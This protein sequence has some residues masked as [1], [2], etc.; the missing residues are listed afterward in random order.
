PLAGPV[1]AAAVIVPSGCRLPGVHDSKR[2]SVAEREQAALLV[3]GRCA[4]GIGVATVEEIDRL[5]ILRATF[6]AMERAIR[7]LPEPA[8]GVLVDGKF[9]TCNLAIPAETVVRGDSRFC[10]IAAASVLAKTHRDAIMR[11][12]DE[13]YPGYGFA[14]HFGYATPEHLER[15]ADLGPSP[16]HRKSFAP[17]REL[18]QLCLTLDE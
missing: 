12:L 6:L 11:E 17:I 7:S 14:H 3:R 2:L 13:Q 8:G 16:I 4:W 9:F 10:E 5:N 1:V 18:E 15:L